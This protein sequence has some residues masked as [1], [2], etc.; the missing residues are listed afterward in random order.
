MRPDAWMTWPWCLL[1]GREM[2]A[3]PAE[4]AEL[5]HEFP[6]IGL[7]QL[8]GLSGQRTQS[9]AQ[10]TLG[11]LVVAVFGRRPGEQLAADSFE[12]RFHLRVIGEVHLTELVDEAGEPIQ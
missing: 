6:G 8:A 9:V 7:R 5:L 2:E 11:G 4:L 10:G 12:L 1:S 3:A